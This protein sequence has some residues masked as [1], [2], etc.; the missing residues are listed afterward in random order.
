MHPSSPAVTAA[1]LP[2]DAFVLDVREDDEWQAGHVDG[3]LHIP[4]GTLLAR[5][6]EVPQDRRVHIMCRVGGRSGQVTQ[7]LA[8]RGWDVVNIDGGM[9]AWEAAGRPMVSESG[10]EPFVA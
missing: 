2:A 6:D 10:T 9:L 7:Y 4:M 5:I 8:A 1:A 3:A